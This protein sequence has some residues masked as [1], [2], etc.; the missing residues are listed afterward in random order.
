MVLMKKYPLFGQL[1]VYQLKEFLKV[2]KYNSI[3]LLK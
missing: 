2:I 3:L 1:L